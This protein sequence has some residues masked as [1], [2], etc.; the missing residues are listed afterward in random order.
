MPET[1]IPAPRFDRLPLA[2][3]VDRDSDTRRMYSTYLQQAI[4]EVEEAEDGR[5][6]L[7]K[8]LTHHPNIIVT[9]TRLPGMNGFDL[10][11][12]LRA[13]E[14]TRSIPIVLV[15][16]DA[17]PQ[18]TKRAEAFGPDAVLV[19]P[20]LP[21][22][23]AQEIRRVL[24]M[25]R[26]VQVRARDARQKAALPLSK[27]DATLDRSGDSIRRVIASRT[28]QRMSTTSPPLAPL[29]LVC[30]NCDR[31]LHYLRS[32]LGGVSARQAEQWDYFECPAGCGN[33]QYRHRTRKLRRVM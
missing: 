20:C 18:D 7:A 15:T 27:A 1:V 24:A 26:E 13:D 19:K 21:E 16:G 5:E 8:A 30:P 12:I 32:H 28:F 31:P 22:R 6:A 33:F 25:S 14:Q 2:L 9:E 11:R 17:F 23:L 3:L 10:C 4:C 29:T